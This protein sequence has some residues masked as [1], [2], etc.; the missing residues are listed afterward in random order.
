MKTSAKTAM[1]LYLQMGFTAPFPL[2]A[3]Q[4][5]PPA[6]GFTGN[7]PPVDGDQLKEAWAKA[8][9]N[10]NI[11]IRLQVHSDLDFEIISVDVDN[12]AS[13]RGEEF[14]QQLEDQLG[15]LH[16]SEIPRS[17]RRGALSPSGQYFFK[18]PQ[19][20]KWD[21]SVTSDVDLVQLTHRY[22]V[23]WPSV[24]P[25][26]SGVPL[27]YRW[28]RGTDEIDVPH[29]NDFPELPEKWIRYL[30]K[31]PIRRL[32]AKPEDTVTTYSE[33]VAWLSTH[34]S[35]WDSDIYDMSASVLGASSGGTLEDS[36]EGNAHDTMVARV[37]EIIRLGIEGNRGIREGL[38]TLSYLF[39]KALNAREQ[40]WRSPEVASRE[41]EDAVVGEVNSVIQEMADGYLE[42]REDI[43]SLAIDSLKKPSV[44]DAARN[45][46]V[47]VDWDRYA[48]NDVG[49]ALMMHDYWGNE[50]KVT[51][52]RGSKAFVIW[53][54]GRGRFSFGHQD[55]VYQHLV[56]AVP[57]R[58]K[59]AAEEQQAKA[60]KI[61]VKLDA[62]QITAEL[63]E[64][65]ELCESYAEMLHKRA[66]PL[67]QTTGMRGILSQLNSLPGAS[68]DEQ[69]LDA[70]RDFIGIQGALTLDIGKVKDGEGYL[71]D[72]KPSDFLTKET[73]VTLQE[74]ATHPAWDKFIHAILPDEEIRRFTRKVMGYSLAAGN[75][76]KL[77]IF[78]SGGAST[79][80]S[81][82]L[83]ACQAAL[84]DYG[85]PMQTSKIYGRRQEGPTPEIIANIDALM[86]TMS[87]TGDGDTLSSN[88]VKQITGNDKLQLRGAHQNETINKSPRF[89]PYASTNSAPR[90][91]D[92]DKALQGRILV[93][94]F[95][96][97]QR[98]RVVPWEENVKENP[99]ILLAVLSW[100]FEG[101]KDFVQEGL[102]RETWPEKVR[103]DSQEFSDDANLLIQFLR[104]T[105]VQTG[106]RDD[107]VDGNTLYQKW[108][109]WTDH[110]GLDRNDA[111]LSRTQ[112]FKKIKANGYPLMINTKVGNKTATLLRGHKLK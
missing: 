34:L 19:G 62:G 40:G 48:D 70:N 21:S 63:E 66:R 67:Y 96:H 8:E 65:L 112:M 13:K 15:S 64:E 30:K 91:D 37:H 7:V 68:I 109:L 85:A 42:V 77:A 89:A 46:P 59:K 1:A 44:E 28:Y 78:L 22:A 11:A 84:G 55:E 110:E 98:N 31:E 50:L 108:K 88:A 4:K 103:K 74:G 47:K 99:E 49:H 56:K 53:D 35:G 111:Q 101:F 69:Q 107:T 94:P 87:E 45:K 82:I 36:L 58:L 6:K 72:S 60:D 97:P 51:K 12:Y 5:S 23:V 80:K 71:R 20:F 81:T 14:I 43:N 105:V 90:V 106:S 38:D 32:K 33:A 100:M 9:D 61:Q 16:R 86:V 18:V 10:A 102:G 29:V 39:I 76:E 93:I 26:E 92:A 52:D 95:E 83:E 27:T 24:V 104:A 17:S 57:D 25:D 73:A 3:E 41:F 79:G 75:P 2:W 54:E